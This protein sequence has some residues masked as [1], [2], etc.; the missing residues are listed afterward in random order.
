M[1]LL[2][3]ILLFI[4]PYNCTPNTDFNK[5]ELVSDKGEK[6]KERA[7]TTVLS[8]IIPKE[9]S[10]SN[11]FSREYFV[12]IA[13]DTS[14]FSCIISQNKTNERIFI[15]LN[16]SALKKT[17][18]SFA[19]ADSAEVTE[20][21]RKFKRFSKP[22]YPEQIKELKLI[23][24]HASKEFDLSKL[25]SLRLSMGTI[26]GFSTN[27]TK[28][29]I[30]QFGE[31]FSNPSNKKVVHLIEDSYLSDDLKRILAPYSL[32]I[33]KC[34]VDGLVYYKPREQTENKTSSE[35]N[36]IFEGFVYFNIIRD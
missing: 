23:L 4:F 30:Q 9:I 2:V 13:N 34:S 36:L 17:Y 14:G 19:L 21:Q 27:I 12:V 16:Y 15:L 28:Q 8:E 33:T 10:T 32:K 3:I 24:D 1:K 31:N 35:G 5:S 11:Y 7:D 20:R 6:L 18:N 26:S 29:Y 25:T 22:N